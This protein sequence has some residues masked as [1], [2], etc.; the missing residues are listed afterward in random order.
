MIQMQKL[1]GHTVWRKANHVDRLDVQSQTCQKGDRDR[2]VILFGGLP[3]LQPIDTTMC[4]NNLNESSRTDDPNLHC[5]VCTSCSKSAYV[6]GQLHVSACEQNTMNAG[7]YIPEA[8]T[9]TDSMG[10]SACQDISGV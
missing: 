5:P 2:T 3:H 8:W 9:S 6:F 7:D 10:S 4:N 1:A